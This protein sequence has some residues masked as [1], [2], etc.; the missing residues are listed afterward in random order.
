MHKIIIAIDGYSGCGKSTTA[1]LVA[2]RLN[3]LY[4]DTGAMYRAVTLYFLENFVSLSNPKQVK[5]AL[6]NIHLEFHRNEHNGIN[7]IFLNGLNV[8]EEIRKM[9]V[10]EQVSQVSAISEVRHLLVEQQR[11]MAKKGGVVMDGRDIGTN[12]FPNAEL[13]IFVT[14]DAYLRAARRQ[15]ELLE[16]GQEVDLDEILQ[17]LSERDRIDTTRK[18]NPLIK[19][20]D[21]YVLDT[22]YV[23]IDEQVDYVIGLYLGKVYP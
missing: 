10:S 12:V 6:L 1:K 19:A 16:K 4:I 11:K 22:S 5:R 2:E 9:Y 18:E 3:Y 23:T 21:A 13:K 15:Q 17:N 14:A 8:E 20:A 7:E